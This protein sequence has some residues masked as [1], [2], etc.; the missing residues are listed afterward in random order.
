MLYKRG[1]FLLI[2]LAA[3]LLTAGILSLPVSASDQDKEK[4]Q[5]I[6]LSALEAFSMIRENTG[7]D[8]FVIIDVR[9]PGE[10][11]AG[12]IENASDINFYSDSFR[13]DLE[14]LDRTRIYLIYCRSGSRSARA[15]RLME[16]LGFVSVYNIKGGINSWAASGLP[17]VR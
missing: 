6:D 5:F 4:K 9:T 8:N 10:Y 13:D 11:G 14:K 16:R 3:V 2:M 17:M 1:K 15:M 7:N 12:H